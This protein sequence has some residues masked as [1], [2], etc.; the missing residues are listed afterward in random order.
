MTA[1]DSITFEVTVDTTTSSG[2]KYI[3]VTL[4]NTPSFVSFAPS[5]Y[6]FHYMQTSNGGSGQQVRLTLFPYNVGI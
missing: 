6:L 3:Y 4:A 2:N 1:M 5:V